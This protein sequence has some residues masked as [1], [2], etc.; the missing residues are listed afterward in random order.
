MTLEKNKTYP[1]EITD[2][3]ADGTGVC[4]IGG[5]VVFVPNSAA[6]DV[7][8]VKIIKVNKTVAYGRME[9]ILRPSPDRISSV[10]PV[11]AVCGGCCYQHISYAAEL[12]I[13]QKKVQ[14]ALRRIAGL[15]LEVSGIVGS[16]QTAGYRNKGQYPVG[17]GEQGVYTGFYRRHSHQ[18]IPVSRCAIQTEAADRLAGLVCE[19]MQAWGIPAYDE[20]KETGLVRHVYVRTGMETGE[21][22]LCLVTTKREV[23]GLEDLAQKAA[24]AVPG[25]CGLVLNLQPKPGN[26]VL[27]ERNITVFGRGE[28]EDV[29][30]GNRF[31]I[32]PL[33]FYQVHH[34]QAENLYACAMEFAAFSGTERVLDLYCGA[35][36]ITLC[37]ARQAAFVTGVEI[38]PAAVVNARENARRNG[39]HHVEFLCMDAGQ[40]AARVAQ[41]GE[42]IDVILVDPPR[43]G[44]DSG[45]VEAILRI[46]PERVV[47]ISCDP[48]TMARDV[49]RLGVR[50]E[51]TACRAFD[52]FPR[53]HHV[54]CVVKLTKRKG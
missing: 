50:Y 54:E 42:K 38:V 33:A 34:D 31:S 21:V 22:L 17:Q 24:A 27:G 25:L 36:T 53:T 37:A 20:Q 5:M 52:L 15:E 19:W 2:Y 49:K 29:L 10:C 48:A 46:A 32:S 11:S 14:D 51:A 45:A 23:P 7:C 13:K 26:K 30:C 8:T 18:I 40:A 4:R 3:T 39:L 47:Y 16:K 9:E 44:L 28:L 6:G 12:R 35:G 43:K 41:T 1:A